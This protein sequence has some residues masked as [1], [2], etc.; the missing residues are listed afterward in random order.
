[1]AKLYFRYGAMGSGKTAHLLMVAF[2][3]AEKGQRAI[4]I[5]PAVDTKGQNKVS[6]RIG[7]EKQV[8]ILAWE[9]DELFEL[10]RARYAYV[11]CVLVDEAQFFTTAQIEQLRQ[12]VIQLDIPVIAYGLRCDSNQQSRPGSRRL[13]E[14]ADKIEELKTVCECGNKATLNCRF[15]KD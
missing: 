12:I 15:D 7:L 13:L 5:K 1:M 9:G 11:D 14:I 6:T 8:D 3:Y 4:I 2:N 10:V